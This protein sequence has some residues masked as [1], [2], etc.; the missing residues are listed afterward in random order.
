MTAGILT[1]NGI[2]LALLEREK[3]GQGQWINTTLLESQIFLL[4]FQAA[5]YL[6]AGEV[7]GQAGNHHPT[8]IPMGTFETKDGYINIAPMGGRWRALFEAV[9]VADLLDV[10]EYLTDAGRSKHRDVINARIGEQTKTKTTA[11]WMAILDALEI[12]AGPVNKM[13]QVFADPQVKHVGIAQ[14]IHSASMER[15]LT[16]VGQPIHLSRTPSEI[17]APAPDLGEH[18]D[19]ILAEHGYDQSAIDDLRSRGI[20]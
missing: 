9:G 12:A 8:Y 13:D 20:I 5:R 17:K 3:S 6:V 10:E 2:L 19:E 16:L 11:E 7:P 18:T 1:A 4:D 14:N 15:D